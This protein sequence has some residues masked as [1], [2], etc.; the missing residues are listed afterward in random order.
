MKTQGTPKICEDDV[1]QTH[2]VSTEIEESATNIAKENNYNTKL[3]RSKVEQLGNKVKVSDS[4][5]ESGLELFCYLGLNSNDEGDIIHCRG[6]VFHEDQLVLQAYPHQIELCSNDKKSIEKYLGDD[7]TD[8]KFFESH[9]GA[10]IRVF[11]YND[12][13]FT[14]THRKLDAFRSKWSCRESFGTIFKRALGAVL[15]IDDDN[16]D[17]GILNKFYNTLDKDKQYYFI[18]S[19]TDD[20]RI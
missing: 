10:L 7:F 17:G 3:T 6:V 9:E 2:V 5:S 13:W 8:Y 18:V 15:N 14:S 16:N 19:N 11:N 1:Q 20:N 4:D 12:K